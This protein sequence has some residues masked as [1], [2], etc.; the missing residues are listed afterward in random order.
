MSVLVI[1]FKGAWEEGKVFE[2]QNRCSGDDALL[3]ISLLLCFFH[4]YR[5]SGY[6]LRFYIVSLLSS[7]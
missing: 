5:L 1:A 6:V 2:K 7:W 3:C 4:G